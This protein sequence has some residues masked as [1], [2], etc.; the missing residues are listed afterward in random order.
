[1]KTGNP[2]PCHPGE[3]LQ[4]SLEE[5]GWGVQEFA[6]ALAISPDT[7]SELMQGHCG[8]SP[9]I[10]IALER[11]GWSNANFWL[12]MQANYDLAQARREIAAKSAAP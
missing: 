10:A 4:D 1:M 9:V 12:R 2:N 11:I 3:V 6:D 7:V 8:I 5:M